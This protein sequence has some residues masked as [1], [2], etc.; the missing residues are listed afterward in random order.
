GAGEPPS[1]KCPLFLKTESQNDKSHLHR[2]SYRP[3][4][5]FVGIIG[6]QNSYD[7]LY[8]KRINKLAL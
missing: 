5:E 3:N 6:E 7:I 4:F 2:N 8:V 1:I